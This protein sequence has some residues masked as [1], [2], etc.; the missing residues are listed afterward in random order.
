MKTF[1]VVNG[2]DVLNN[3][4][5]QTKAFQRAD[6][7]FEGTAMCVGC[8]MELKIYRDTPSGL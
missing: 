1:R 2:K 8:L 7:I 3:E 6:T 5:P 4:V